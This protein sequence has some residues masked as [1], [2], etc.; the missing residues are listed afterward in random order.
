M[1]VKCKSKCQKHQQT[2]KPKQMNT[3]KQNYRT[4]TNE[5]TQKKTCTHKCLKDLRWENMKNIYIT[6]ENTTNKFKN[7]LSSMSISNKIFK[8]LKNRSKY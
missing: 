2:C 8:V 1:D 3:N 6:Q 4:Q 5:Y 7:F